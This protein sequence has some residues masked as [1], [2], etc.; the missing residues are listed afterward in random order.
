[1]GA[2]DDIADKQEA[3]SVEL[4]EN[5]AEDFIRYHR[6]NVVGHEERGWL[7]YLS[8][9]TGWVYDKNCHNNVLG[10]GPPGSGKSLTKNTVENL[11][12]SGDKYTKTDAS[13]NAILDSVEWD[14]ALVAPMDEYD[15]IDKAITE[16]L[17][18]SNPVDDGYSKD[19]NVEDPDAKGGYSPEEVSAD[20]N[21]WVVLYAPSSKKG[22]VDDELE[23]RALIL[24]FSNDKH[25]RRGIMRKEFGHEN[26]NTS[27]GDTEYIYDT[28][29]LAARLREHVREF[30]TTTHYDEGEDGDQYPVSRT[31]DTLVT[32]PLWVAYVCEPIFDLD[33]DH[34][35]RTFSL[36]RNAIKAS[37]LLNHKERNTK[38]VEV[39]VDEDS[40]E[41][42]TREAVVVGPQDV[43]NVLACLPTLLSTTHQLTPL[44]RHVLDAVDA[45]EGIT[46]GD[47]TT[48]SQVQDW[49]DD[50]DIPHPSRSTLKE[51]MDDL[52]EE[53]YLQKYSGAGGPNGKA[54]VYEKHDEGALQAPNIANLQQKAQRRDGLDLDEE[55]VDIDPSDPFADVRDPFRDQP[56]KETVYAFEEEFS[57]SSTTDTTD[58][59]DFMGPSN[60][61]SEDET[62]EDDG[63]QATLT[64]AADDGETDETVDTADSSV[65]L[66]PEG[67]PDNPT[68]MYVY[69]TLYEHANGET[70][71]P[72]ET[73]P[74]QM[75]EL[76]DHPSKVDV[77]GT[78][79]DPDHELWQDRPDHTDDRVISEADCLRELS[80]AYDELKQKGVIVED[81][82]TAPPGMYVVRVASDI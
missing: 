16:V 25:T 8:L 61:E 15:K 37:A 77:T 23:D 13:S 18:S 47:G 80:D 9:L 48:V 26:I 24:Y 81:E 35:N 53:Y 51:R 62:E 67:V 40:T 49:L 19:R 54:D 74:E 66:E 7:M 20:A 6:G 82:E 31:G 63:G 55:H 71:G 60:D 50:N 44:K 21:P 5:V 58:A 32:I 46:D 36:V 39:Y 14:L 34:S 38:E 22:G 59:S 42:K 68:Q 79:V 43:A 12:D 33:A 4:S 56:F 3:A 69:D 17:K 27:R 11:F 57:G 75:G 45:T 78:A 76:Q 1:V 64:S 72:S 2:F 65:E 41:T 52:A 10:I 30:P 28:Q 29:G 73:V 70:F